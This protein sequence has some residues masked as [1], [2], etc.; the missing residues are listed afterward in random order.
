MWVWPETWPGHK[1]GLCGPVRRTAVQASHDGPK[2]RSA[3]RR[4]QAQL[5]RGAAWGAVSAC[6]GGGWRLRQRPGQQGIRGQHRSK[7]GRQARSKQ[8]PEVDQ[9]TGQGVP[10]LRLELAARVAAAPH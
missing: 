10:G 5:A 1:R 6:Q 3:V 9:P 8:R 4:G 2:T 7:V